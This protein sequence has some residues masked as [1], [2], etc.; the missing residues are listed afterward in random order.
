MFF[1]C[2]IN[3]NQSSI[4]VIVTCWLI[5]IILCALFIEWSFACQQI[6]GKITSKRIAQ[7]LEACSPF[8]YIMVDKHPYRHD[9]SHI[10]THRLQSTITEFSHYL[11]KVSFPRKTTR[12]RTL[13]QVLNMMVW[14]L[15]N[16]YFCSSLIIYFHLQYLQFTFVYIL[17]SETYVMS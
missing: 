11:H 2:N 14:D 7:M 8:S 17:R 16:N 4:K 15:E 6:G 3:Y 12:W 1:C 10:V 13:L 9:P 5:K